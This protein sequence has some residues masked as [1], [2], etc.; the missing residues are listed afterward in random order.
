MSVVRKRKRPPPLK[1]R[2]VSKDGCPPLVGER[3]CPAGGCAEVATG[4]ARCARAPGKRCCEGARVRPAARLIHPLERY[5][6]DG[7][8]TASGLVDPFVNLSPRRRMPAVS[9]WRGTAEICFVFQ[10]PR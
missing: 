5:R 7:H 10:T 2:P 3:C 6:L 9:R 4:A 8:D 1:H